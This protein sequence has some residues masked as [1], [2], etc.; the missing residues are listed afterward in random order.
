MHCF[1]CVTFPAIMPTLTVGKF[2]CGSLRFSCCCYQC[3]WCFYPLLF[4]LSLCP[5]LVYKVTRSFCFETYHYSFHCR[6]SVDLYQSHS[7]TRLRQ[8]FY[9][10]IISNYIASLRLPP[11]K[12]S[13]FFFLWEDCSSTSI[14]LEDTSG[15]RQDWS[16]P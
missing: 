8:N 10:V 13:I 16:P 11:Q 15:C 2:F 4:S 9:T 12:A 3:C 7:Y 14:S 1:L 5:L 6:S